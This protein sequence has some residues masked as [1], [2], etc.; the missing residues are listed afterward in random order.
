MCFVGSAKCKILQVRRILRDLQP[1]LYRI[2]RGL[3]AH[4]DEG[5]SPVSPYLWSLQEVVPKL[6][7]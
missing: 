1:A 7:C 2:I 6:T 4:S 3:D 5:I